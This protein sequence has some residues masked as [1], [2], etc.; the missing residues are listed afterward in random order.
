VPLSA[1]CA[2]S[3]ARFEE[4]PVKQKL[5]RWYWC[6]VFGELYGGANETRFAL[7]LPG[8]IRWIET[9]EEPRT[10]RDSNFTPVRLLSLQSRLSAA[11]KGL[12][13][14]LMQVGSR[15]FLNGDPIELT[16]YFDLA[17]DIHHIFP[18]SYC[19]KMGLP[20][21]RW[22]SVVNKAPLSSRTNRI[23]G[24]RA[25]SAYVAS[26]ERNHHIAPAHLDQILA[27]HCVDPPVLRQDDFDSF[28]RS[29]AARLLDLIEQATGK[30]VLGR[31]SDEVTIAF[32]APLFPS[33]TPRRAEEG[34]GQRTSSSVLE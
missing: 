5:A 33:G 10:V 6:G 25:P 19:E 12:M 18:A 23:I 28:I 32:G 8:V 9:G 16:T 21:A 26:L 14:L 11:Y 31:D 30:S 29:R 4:E 17:I 22:N 20:K 27:S 3:G 2:A 1:I 7:D 34:T 15:D 24:G 13:A